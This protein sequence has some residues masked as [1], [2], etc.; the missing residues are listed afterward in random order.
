MSALSGAPGGYRY[1]E[2]KSGGRPNKA[3]YHGDKAQ[4]FG[5]KLLGKK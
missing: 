2:Y 5:R 4:A 3:G 1:L